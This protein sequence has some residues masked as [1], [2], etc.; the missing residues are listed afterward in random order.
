[1]WLSV[2]PQVLS[3]MPFVF[4]ANFSFANIALAHILFLQDPEWAASEARES[5]DYADL[6]QGVINR[7]TTFDALDEFKKVFVKN[8]VR[9]LPKLVERVRQLKDWYVARQLI[10]SSAPDDTTRPIVHSMLLD[11]GNMPFIFSFG[12]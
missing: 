3:A 1:M 2:P 5:I 10:I 11:K 9:L 6:L 8:S 4:L 12:N 7:L